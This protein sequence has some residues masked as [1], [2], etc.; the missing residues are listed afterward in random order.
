MTPRDAL[1][2]IFVDPDSGDELTI[3]SYFKLLLSTLMA[4]GE[5][6]SG[7]RPFGNSGWEGNL[8]L[9]LVKAGCIGGTVV[10]SLY[11]EKT[12]RYE[13]IGGLEFSQLDKEV[14]DS[15]DGQCEVEDVST[16]EYDAFIQKMIGAL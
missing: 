10:Y 4:E 8:E 14:I 16:S 2:L 6:F 12:E 15:G 13:E 3:R 5:S 11:N 7:K 1:E 9:P